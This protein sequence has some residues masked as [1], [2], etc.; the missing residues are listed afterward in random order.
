LQAPSPIQVIQE[1]VVLEQIQIE[2][3]E[4]EAVEEEELPR[5]Q[6]EIE[7]PRQEQESITRR[8]ATT[9]HAKTRQQHI[10]REIARFAEV[11]YTIEILC[12]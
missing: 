8:L 11:Q 9:Q 12:Q 5:V 6:Q 4:D 7:R 3:W 10:N 1:F 2:D